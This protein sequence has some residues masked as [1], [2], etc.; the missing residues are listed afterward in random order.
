MPCSLWKRTGNHNQ[1]LTIARSEKLTKKSCHDAHTKNERTHC[2]LF[3]PAMVVVAVLLPDNCSL[4][5]F[6]PC[7]R[8]CRF[9]LAV[10]AEA[11]PP[12]AAA[13]GRHSSGC[14]PFRRAST[15]GFFFGRLASIRKF[16][17][18]EKPRRPLI[19]FCVR[20]QRG[21]G[22]RGCIGRLTLL[23]LQ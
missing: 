2:A 10:L 6:G 12:R 8:S 4:L 17:Q 7:W 13:H 16:R 20:R 19:S 14:F 3:M 1:K 18:S 15:S 11:H 23:L 9:R 21:R 5:C 22:R